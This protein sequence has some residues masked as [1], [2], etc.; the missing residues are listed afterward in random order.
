MNTYD[1]SLHE[2][3]M[4]AVYHITLYAMIEHC[5]FDAMIEYEQ[6]VLMV[7]MIRIVHFTQ[8]RKVY[9]LHSVK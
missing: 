4:Y 5:K 3:I 2:H 9:T 1:S 6:V 8:Y 7:L